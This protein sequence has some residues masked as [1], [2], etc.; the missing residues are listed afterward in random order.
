M[1]KRLISIDLLRAIAVLLIL[2][3]R[4]QFSYGDYAVLATG[5]ALG[6]GLFFVLSGYSVAVSSVTTLKEWIIKR[7]GRLIPTILVAAFICH[8]GVHE[9]F[10]TTFMWFIHCLVLYSVGL[11]FIKRYAMK[12]IFHII[13]A[14][15]AAYLLYFFSYGHS[16]GAMYGAT[17]GKYFIFFLFYLCGFALRT[18]PIS[19]KWHHGHIAVCLFSVFLIAADSLLRYHLIHCGGSD[20]L[21]ILSPML[22]IPGLLGL[23]YATEPLN[24]L[25]ETCGFRLYAAPFLA[26]IGALSLEVYIGIGTIN[27]PIQ[28]FLAPLF[29][30]NIPLVM[31]SVLFYCYLL[32]CC[33]RLL[34]AIISGNKE[35]LT[36]PHVLKP[37]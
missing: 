13:T 4:M 2:N 25:S 15:I 27:Q 9:V 32:R 3:H 22:L 35:T 11:Y 33:T 21:L 8:Y 19:L 29:P 23:F 5:G 7:L 1:N 18:H 20:Y 26:T 12:Y 34:L 37:Y 6:C 17:C 30:F 24:H 31:V 16:E 14:C 28:R 10:G 36:L